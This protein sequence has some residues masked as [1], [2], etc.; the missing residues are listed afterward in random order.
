MACFCADWNYSSRL[1]HFFFL[2]W[3]SSLFL[4]LRQLA[5]SL[6]NFYLLTD[7]P[8][9]L[10]PPWPL[11]GRP[12]TRL[13]LVHSLLSRFC[14]LKKLAE[15]SKDR[16]EQVEKAKKEKWWSE[17]A[18]NGKRAPDHVEKR[19]GSVIWFTHRPKNK[20]R[21]GSK[22]RQEK[23]LTWGFVVIKTFVLYY[24]TVNSI[25]CVARLTSHSLPLK[26]DQHVEKDIHHRI[27]RRILKCYFYRS[28]IGYF[29]NNIE[30]L[31]LPNLVE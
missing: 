30:L 10:R 20:R 24:S 8:H 12:R 23:I 13:S 31:M 15:N 2:I 4:Q 26:R 6:R 9:F 18:R 21:G 29:L 25:K 22:K 17:R 1:E 3:Y 7:S 11:V 16:L 5:R 27:L 19:V 14:P 28:R